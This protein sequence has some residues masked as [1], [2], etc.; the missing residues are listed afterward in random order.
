MGLESTKRT[1]RQRPEEKERYYLLPGQGGSNY[2][3][4]QKRIVKYSII[5]GLIVSALFATV[6]YFVYRLPNGG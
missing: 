2:R 3:R 5:V 1:L 6:M 4:K